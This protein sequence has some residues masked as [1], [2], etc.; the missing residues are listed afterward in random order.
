MRFFEPEIHNLISDQLTT[1]KTAAEFPIIYYLVALLWQIFG[2]HEFIFRALQVLTSFFGLWCLFR[3]LSDLFKD[4]LWAFFVTFL[5]FTA[6]MYVYYTNNFISNLPALN[7]VFIAWFFFHKWYKSHRSKHL[8]LSTFFF[9]LGFLLK[10]TAGISFAALSAILLLDWFKI[11]KFKKTGRIFK[12]PLKPILAFASVYFLVFIWYIYAFFYNKNHGGSVSPLKLRPIWALSGE[13]ISEIWSKI[14]NKWVHDYFNISVLIISAILLI[15][16]FIR[17]K[18]THAFLLTLMALIFIGSTIFCLFWFRSLGY[19]DYY[20]IN[21]LVLPIIIFS[22]TILYLQK[23]YP[24]AFNSIIVKS[25][26]I[27]YLCFNFYYCDTNMQERYTK[28]NYNIRKQQLNFSTISTYNRSLGINKGDKVITMS[29]PSFNISL[30]LMNLKGWTLTLSENASKKFATFIK[31]GAKYLFVNKPE[32]LEADFMQVYLQKKIG[33][34]YNISIFDLRHLS[35]P[36]LKTR[37]IIDDMTEFQLYNSYKNY[38][39]T[40]TSSAQNKIYLN[41]NEQNVCVSVEIPKKATII[42][43]VFSVLDIETNEWK[44]KPSGYDSVF[45]SVK[46]DDQYFEEYITNDTDLQDSLHMVSFMFSNL[47]S[48][49]PATVRTNII[50]EKQQIVFYTNN[51]FEAISDCYDFENPNKKISQEHIVEDVAFSGKRSYQYTEK[52]EYGPLIKKYIFEFLYGTPKELTAKISI[53]PKQVIEK[54]KVNMVISIREGD[55]S[56]FYESV[57]F[58]CTNEEINQWHELE[59]SIGMPPGLSKEAHIGV[60]IWNPGGAIFYIDDLC[61]NYNY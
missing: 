38:F 37:E 17:A 2:H 33:Q 34:Y 9:L 13:Y 43:I 36:P 24:K 49:I 15:F 44:V 30:Y 46:F 3:L 11:I 54:N 18:K 47:S 7:M 28:R 6:P 5:V 51:N 56:H 31:K 39:N 50:Y 21:L 23:Y 48:E 45:M 52:S 14:S 10:I 4:L 58:T 57:S 27:A 16:L 42:D 59:Y 55:K 8:Y 19:H 61:V 29:D 53:Y 41:P 25:I 12:K 26:F 35:S 22:T 60:Y 20:V 32:V 1:G 40:S